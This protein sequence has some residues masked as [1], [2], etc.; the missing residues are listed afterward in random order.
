MAIRNAEVL[1]GLLWLIPLVV[2]MYINTFYGLLH[3]VATSLNISRSR[4]KLKWIGSKLRLTWVY[5]V[6]QGIKLD[7]NDF[8]KNLLANYFAYNRL[9]T[10]G[11]FNN[12]YYTYDY[13]CINISILFI[14]INHIIQENILVESTFSHN[15]DYFNTLVHFAHYWTSWR[16]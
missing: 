16:Q 3:P 7:E 1:Y 14:L 5:L 8:Y 12:S 13:T 11:N 10:F 4:S 2:W 6:K 9:G 15:N